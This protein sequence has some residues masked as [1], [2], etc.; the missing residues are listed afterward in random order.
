M[1]KAGVHAAK[2]LEHVSCL[3]TAQIKSPSAAW[4]VE[5]DAAV[6][7]IKQGTVHTD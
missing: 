6:T 2:K 4:H 3:S 5:S 7:A 1:E